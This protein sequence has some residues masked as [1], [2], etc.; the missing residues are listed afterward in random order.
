MLFEVYPE[1]KK[2][3]EICLRHTPNL[4]KEDIA[5]IRAN[6]RQ[7]VENKNAELISLLKK[8]SLDDINSE[9]NSIY[10]QIL[11]NLDLES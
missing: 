6:Y 9:L 1:Q 4:P 3:L 2:L 10:H 7:N 5:L 11:Y 8:V